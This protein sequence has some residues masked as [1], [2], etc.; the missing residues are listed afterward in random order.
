MAR[1]SHLPPHCQEKGLLEPGLLSPN[2]NS[3]INPLVNQGRLADSNW[4]QVEPIPTTVS[5]LR[6]KVKVFFFIWWMSTDFYL[7]SSVAAHPYD[8]SHSLSASSSTTS[9]SSSLLR[10]QTLR[11]SHEGSTLLSQFEELI[12][13]NETQRQMIQEIYLATG[14][15]KQKSAAMPPKSNERPPTDDLPATV[16]KEWLR[17]AIVSLTFFFLCRLTWNS[18]CN[19]LQRKILLFKRKMTLCDG[20]SNSFVA[21]I[22]LALDIPQL[23]PTLYVILP[24]LNSSLPSHHTKAL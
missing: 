11:T 2:G 6:R 24:S 7:N 5:P 10:G 23:Y 20:K 3:T 9:P 13:S 8:S 18:W 12:R 17:G 15:H 21:Y 16:V 14:L 19:R 22:S 1:M 4:P